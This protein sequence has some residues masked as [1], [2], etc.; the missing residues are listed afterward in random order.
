MYDLVRPTLF[1]INA[2][3]V[4]DGPTCE[5]RIFWG[6]NCSFLDGKFWDHSNYAFSKYFFF[7]VGMPKDESIILFLFIKNIYSREKIL[8][9]IPKDKKVHMWNLVPTTTLVHQL[10]QDNYKS[11]KNKWVHNKYEINK[12]HYTKTQTCHHQSHM[13]SWTQSQYQPLKPLGT[14]ELETKWRQCLTCIHHKTFCKPSETQHA[15]KKE[16]FRWNLNFP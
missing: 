9:K 5:Q 6:E 10:T 4:V 16:N 15:R 8:L 3:N 2:L 14:Q 12:Q 11:W 13:A 1:I 7:Y